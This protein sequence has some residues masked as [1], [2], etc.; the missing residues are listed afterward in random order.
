[1]ARSHAAVAR[2]KHDGAAADGKTKEVFQRKF[3]C[4]RSRLR[5]CEHTLARDRGSIDVSQ[6][7]LLGLQSYRVP[8]QFRRIG[9]ILIGASGIFAWYTA[10][11][12]KEQQR[13]K[14][15]LI[16]GPKECRNIREDLPKPKMR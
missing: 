1:L 3:Y 15:P 12:K 6:K 11:A 2:L 5:S 14:R 8:I 16:K 4:R 10:R 7:A 9:K 13:R